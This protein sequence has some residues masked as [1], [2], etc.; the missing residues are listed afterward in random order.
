VSSYE[1]TASVNLTREGMLTKADVGELGG[2]NCIRL[3]VVRVKNTDCPTSWIVD[4]GVDPY[5]ERSSVFSS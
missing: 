3:I 5:E 2:I 1:A 4:C